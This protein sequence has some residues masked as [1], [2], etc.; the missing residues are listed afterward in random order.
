MIDE[1]TISGKIA[2][3][4]FESM[5]ETGN[6]PDTI[7]NE[8]GL[9]QVSDTASIETIIDKVIANNP[10]QL[11][12]YKAGKAALFAF[13]VG[14]VMKETKGQANPKIVNELLKKKLI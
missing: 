10:A 11:S 14:Q 3:E 1:G 4:V 13:F 2:K 5:Y 9:K 12:Q 6:S 7:V 8:K